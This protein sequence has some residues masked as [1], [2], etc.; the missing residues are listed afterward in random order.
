M[1]AVNELVG[2]TAGRKAIGHAERVFTA[3]A[4]SLAVLA[5]SLQ[6]SPDSASLELALSPPAWHF[7]PRQPEQS[8]TS[9]SKG[10]KRWES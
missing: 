3:A 6:H 2:G 9:L 4:V 8:A 10:A 7:A 5:F 1:T